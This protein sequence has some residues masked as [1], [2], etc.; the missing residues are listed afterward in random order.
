MKIQ[1]QHIVKVVNSFMAAATTYNVVQTF[2]RAGLVLFVEDSRPFCR[3]S[4]FHAKA[5]LKKIDQVPLPVPEEDEEAADIA[6]DEI[7]EACHGTDF[8]D[9]FLGDFSDN[10][11]NGTVSRRPRRQEGG[12]LEFRNY[13]DFS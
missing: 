13:W 4:R 12:R 11:D 3:V 8:A 10:D 1:T 7:Y 5:L 2:R 6:D 9:V